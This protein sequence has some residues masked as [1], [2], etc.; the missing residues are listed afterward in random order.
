MTDIISEVV[1]ELFWLML[2]RALSPTAR[3]KCFA[4]GFIR[5]RLESESFEPLIDF[6]AFLVQKL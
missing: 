3:P 6:L 5:N 4:E 2:P 1:L